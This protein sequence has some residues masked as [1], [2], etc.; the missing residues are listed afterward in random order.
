MLSL[1]ETL[2][3][4]VG[5]G[6]SDFD[7]RPLAKKR[8]Y[9][10]RKVPSDSVSV[11]A[12]DNSRQNTNE[13]N[14]GMSLTGKYLFDGSSPVSFTNELGY[15]YVNLQQNSSTKRTWRRAPDD[16]VEIT[17]YFIQFGLHETVKKFAESLKGRSDNS[18]YQGLLS[19]KKRV[20]EARKNNVAAA[21]K[22]SRGCPPFYGLEVDRLVKAEVDKIINLGLSVDGQTLRRIVTD[23]LTERNMLHLLMDHGGRNTIGRGFAERFYKRHKLVT[24]S[25]RARRTRL[26]AVINNDLVRENLV[27]EGDNITEEEQQQVDKRVYLRHNDNEDGDDDDSDSDSNDDSNASIQNDI[28]SAAAN[29]IV[30]DG[31]HGHDDS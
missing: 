22:E 8:K 5:N 4:S 15:H 28:V 3:Q 20:L 10:A 26:P 12:E 1:V 2:K 13:I 25:S 16:W 31:D 18:I 17:E 29:N 11:N 14:D 9:S 19:W 24:R 21:F 27:I 23:I 6:L 30:S 7:L